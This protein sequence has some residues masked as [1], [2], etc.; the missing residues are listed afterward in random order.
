MKS[1]GYRGHNIDFENVYQ[2][3][4]ALYN[5]FIKYAVERL[6]PE[7]FFVSTALAP[8][9]SAEQKRFAL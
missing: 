1:K 8:K 6:Y 9:L 4:R 3:D 7:G 2:G 5:Q